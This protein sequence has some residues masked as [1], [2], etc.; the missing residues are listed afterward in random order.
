MRYNKI[1][2]DKLFKKNIQHNKI[3]MLNAPSFNIYLQY[4]YLSVPLLTGQLQKFGFNVY[5][6]D[7]A[8]DFFLIYLKKNI[9]KKF[10][11]KS[12]NFKKNMEILIK[13][14]LKKYSIYINLLKKTLLIPRTLMKLTRFLY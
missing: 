7:F 5:T 10:I 14:N 3:L 8:F 1:M 4:P 13:P 12:K 2:F 6:K 11:I 9:S